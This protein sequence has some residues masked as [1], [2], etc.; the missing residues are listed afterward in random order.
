VTVRIEAPTIN[1]QVENMPRRESAETNEQL[2]S[3]SAKDGIL[4]AIRLMSER[5]VKSVLVRDESNLVTGVYRL[6]QNRVQFFPSGS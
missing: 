6:E 2:P 1:R 4:E 5:H 3:C